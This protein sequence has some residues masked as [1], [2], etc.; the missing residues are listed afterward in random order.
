MP[1][2]E[3]HCEEIVALPGRTPQDLSQLQE[4]DRV[5]GPVR[6]YHWEGQHPRREE[7]ERLSS[8]SRALLRQWDR[9][10]EQ[11]G[12][13]R[14]IR[15]PGGGPKTFQVLLPRCLQE[16][17]LQSVHDQQGHQGM[18]RTLQLLRSRCFW[19]NMTQDAERWCQQ[20][21]RCV[22]GKAVQPK[23][24]PHWGTLQASQ[25][26]EILALDFTILEP[27]SDRRENVLVL[28]DIFTKYMSQV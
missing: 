20:C 16:E 14:L 10:V 19:P 23:V 17:V 5:I 12:L 11:D 21:Q 24:R 4:A 6:R 22:F 13:Y 27:A 8:A 25:P 3:G 26:N 15:A 9:L 18:E 2:M 7:R 28:T 1:A